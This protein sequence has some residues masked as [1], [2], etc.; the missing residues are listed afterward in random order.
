MKLK[1]LARI[2][3]LSAITI[4]PLSFANSD[5]L[6]GKWKTIDDRT[7]YSLS[8]IVISKVQDGSYT[9]TIVDIR[10]VPGATTLTNCQKCTGELKNKPLLG[11][12]PLKNLKMNSTNKTEF[13]GGKYIDPRTGHEYQTKARLSNNG[14]HLIIRN[15]SPT[16]TTGRNITWVKY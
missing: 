1:H 14:K 13:S 16:V 10:A 15:T 9:A 3:L 2:A 4:S 11:F 8:D 7:G 12:T 5:P 6:V